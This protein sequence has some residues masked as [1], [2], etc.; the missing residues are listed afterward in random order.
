MSYPLSRQSLLVGVLHEVDCWPSYF[1]VGGLVF[2]PLSLP[3]LEA[4]YG[5]RKWRT[6]APVA[7]LSACAGQKA[8]ASQEVVL[9]VQVGGWGGGSGWVARDSKESS[10]ILGATQPRCHRVSTADP[11][12]AEKI[13]RQPWRCVPGTGGQPYC[14][15]FTG[16]KAVGCLGLQHGCTMS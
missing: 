15:T 8:H 11:P 13:R 5:P 1:I 6:L 12:G 7:V 9:L 16:Q 14:S 4:M 3:C 10:A 2:A